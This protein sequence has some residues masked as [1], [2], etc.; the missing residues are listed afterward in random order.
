MQTETVAWECSPVKRILSD[1]TPRFTF[2]SAYEESPIVSAIDE[3]SK[4]NNKD[5]RIEMR[6][7]K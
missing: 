5:E 4:K 1:G 7:P 6:S 3:I 2:L